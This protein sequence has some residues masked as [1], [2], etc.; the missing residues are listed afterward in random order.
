MLD[1]LLLMTLILISSLVAYHAGYE[2][3]LGIKQIYLRSQLHQTRKALHSMLR[4]VEKTPNHSQRLEYLILNSEQELDFK[5]RSRQVA[6][7]HRIREATFYASIAVTCSI[8][9]AFL[10]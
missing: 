9:V 6:V 5:I 10:F 8:F 7:T 4:Q 3:F 2:V 1:T